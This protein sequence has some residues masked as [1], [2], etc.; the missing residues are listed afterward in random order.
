MTELTPLTPDHAAALLLAS[1]QTLRAEVEALGPEAMRWH[2][3]E[4]E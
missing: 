4:G 3:A 2:P 1:M